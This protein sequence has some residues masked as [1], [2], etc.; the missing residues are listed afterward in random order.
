LL[1]VVLSADC[2]CC[3]P[4]LLPDCES[5]RSASITR[6]RDQYN[7]SHWRGPLEAWVASDASAVIEHTK[8]W[9]GRR[10]LGLQLSARMTQLASK[11]KLSAQSAGY[12]GREFEGCYLPA[13]AGL[14]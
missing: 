12:A 5:D 13:A 10:F 2:M 8:R 3:M 6:L 11:Y 14:P 9:V 4:F 7:E 1:A